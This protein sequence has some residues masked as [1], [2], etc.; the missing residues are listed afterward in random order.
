MQQHASAVSLFNYSYNF[1][2]G[3]LKIYI[4][5]QVADIFTYFGDS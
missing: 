5:K 3:L 4:F 1:A 2:N